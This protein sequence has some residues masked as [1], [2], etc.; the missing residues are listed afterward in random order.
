M[1][2]I[3]FTEKFYGHKGTDER[4]SDAYIWNMEAN[5][6][7]ARC[8]ALFLLIF[9][10]KI[11]T[12]SHKLE[13]LIATLNDAEKG[14]TDPNSHRMTMATVVNGTFFDGVL[15]GSRIKLVYY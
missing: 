2:T 5:K 14:L 10:L 11:N 8:C 15:T 7:L 9:F 6:H 4:I 1:I 12:L 3:L 13:E